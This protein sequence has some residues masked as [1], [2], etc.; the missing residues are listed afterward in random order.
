MF[1]NNSIICKNVYAIVSTSELEIYANIILKKG[2][3]LFQ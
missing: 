2:V 1:L 3:V